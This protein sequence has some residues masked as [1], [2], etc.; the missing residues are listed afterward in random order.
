M[1]REKTAATAAKT[2]TAAAT[3][4]EAIVVTGTASPDFNKPDVSG[5]SD[6]V[7]VAS[8]LQNGITFLGL[9]SAPETQ[10]R[11]TIAG[12]NYRLKG[13]TNAGLL[14]GPGSSVLVSLPRAQWE[15]IK[16]RYKSH[17]AFAHNPPF[18]R[19]FGSENDY[20]SA[21]AQSELKEVRTGCEP[22]KPAL[23]KDA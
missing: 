3:S 1:A 11:V 12:I 13:Q 21:A 23:G 4:A 14:A 15:E 18:L 5:A 9:K 20:R 17:P 10:G 6:R 2:T 19:E 8:S 22:V 7:Y 16:A